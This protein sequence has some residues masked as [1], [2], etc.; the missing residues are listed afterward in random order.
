MVLTGASCLPRSGSARAGIATTGPR[1]STSCWPPERAERQVLIDHWAM[2]QTD[3]GGHR[4]YSAGDL[5]EHGHRGVRETDRPASRPRRPPYGAGRVVHVIRPPGPAAASC[6]RP[7]A[8]AA[9][10]GHRPQLRVVP[11]VAAEPR[12]WWRGQGHFRLR[13]LP[14]P[15]RTRRAVR[16]QAGRT[17]VQPGNVTEPPR[18]TDR[19]H[20]PRRAARHPVCG[21]AVHARRATRSASNQIRRTSCH[22]TEVANQVSPR[23]ITGRSARE[24][25]SRS[26][27]ART[28]ASDIDRHRGGPAGGVAG[29]LRARVEAGAQWAFE[30]LREA[31]IDVDAVLDL[32]DDEHQGDEPAEDE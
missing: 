4:A 14:S 1:T 26:R 20:Q 19:L 28:A 29:R 9:A 32:D 15:T 16:Q 13:W 27:P 31:G 12:P 10:P 21:A 8:T 23:D 11:R 3:D 5:A 17:A 7:G 6:A 2:A 30:V 18:L 25:F 22:R 24:L